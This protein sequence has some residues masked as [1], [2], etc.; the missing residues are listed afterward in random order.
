[1]A[2]L[3]SIICTKNYWNRTTIVEV[4]VGGWVVSFLDTVYNANWSKQQL[5]RR[6][7][8]GKTYS[9]DI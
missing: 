8:N 7:T 9:R 3:L 2:Y 1:M 4:I 5:Q 6:Y